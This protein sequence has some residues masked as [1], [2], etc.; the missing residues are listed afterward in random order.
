[1]ANNLLVVFGGTS[2]DTRQAIYNTEDLRSK[3]TDVLQFNLLTTEPSVELQKSS[4]DSVKFVEG[5]PDA[6]RSPIRFCTGRFGIKYPCG[7]TGIRPIGASVVNR[8]QF[9]GSD[10]SSLDRLKDR[11]ESVNWSSKLS[12]ASENSEVRG[13]NGNGYDFG[14]DATAVIRDF[15]AGSGNNYDNIFIMGHSRGH[16]LALRAADPNNLGPSGSEKLKRVV[17][18][19]PVNKNVGSTDR[20]TIIPESQRIIK[21]LTTNNKEVHFVVAKKL[22]GIQNTFNSD[23][24]AYVGSGINLSRESLTPILDGNPLQAISQIRQGISQAVDTVTDGINSP[25]NPTIQNTYVHFA[26]TNHTMLEAG[27][28]FRGNFP[29][30]LELI[31]PKWDDGTK[32]AN[33]AAETFSADGPAMQAYIDGKISTLSLLS[34]I[35]I[36]PDEPLRELYTGLDPELIVADRLGAA[37]HNLA[38]RFSSQANGSLPAASPNATIVDNSEEPPNEDDASS[39]LDSQESVLDSQEIA[40]QISQFVQELDFKPGQ[41]NTDL[42]GETATSRETSLDPSG[43]SDISDDVLFGGDASQVIEGGEG[44]DWLNGNEGKDLLL[45][46]TGEDLVHGGKGDDLLTGDEGDDLLSGDLGDDI[47]IG[48]AGSD[49]FA[50]SK[51]RGTDTILDFQDGID[52]FLLVPQV[53]D[54]LLPIEELT[55]SFVADGNNTNILLGND[56]IA[57]VNNITPDRITAEDFATYFSDPEL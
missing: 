2:Q 24:G 46:G 6:S 23:I 8:E 5:A 18:L 14:L 49:V 27:G 25:N 51:G 55:P 1:M 26:G 50:L 31:S 41:A 36:L 54:E 39:V 7:F 20:D 30:Y 37:F 13:M 43:D 29:S 15:L 17:L 9:P 28:N 44:E 19:D 16:A 11:M 4:G 33:L 45:G 32:F 38:R 53:G 10:T 3:Q 35:A 40:D 34:G 47:L 48:G 21:N 52:R 56:V 57:K 12:P 42:D 22:D